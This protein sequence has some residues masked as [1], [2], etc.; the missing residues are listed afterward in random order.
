MKQGITSLPAQ[1]LSRLYQDGFDISYI[2]GRGQQRYNGYQSDVQKQTCL[3][4]GHQQACSTH[5]ALHP[6][7]SALSLG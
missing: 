3:Q 7:P 4:N 1:F 5:S 2:V 6:A